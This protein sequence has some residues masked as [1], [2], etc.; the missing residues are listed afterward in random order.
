M[1]I[2]E[3]P[4]LH[5]SREPHGG[6]PSLPFSCHRRP[7]GHETTAPGAGTEPQ[8]MDSAGC[9]HREPLCSPRG[10]TSPVVL[11]PEGGVGI[12]PFFLEAAGL[13]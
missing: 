8:G 11:V 6:R 2:I 7:G 10:V 13:G 5:G 1:G 12:T 9:A 3:L 4:N